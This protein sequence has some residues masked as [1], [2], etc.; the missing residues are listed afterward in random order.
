MN[1]VGSP[2]E[3][4]QRKRGDGEP[5]GVS[6]SINRKTKR[7]AKAADIGKKGVGGEFRI[8]RRVTGGKALR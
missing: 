5:K 7:E 6:H 1:G 2:R 4:Y 8:A 3:R